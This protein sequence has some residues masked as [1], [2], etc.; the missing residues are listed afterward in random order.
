MSSLFSIRLPFEL[1][2]FQDAPASQDV[3]SQLT[4]KT[5]SHPPIIQESTTTIQ[6]QQRTLNSSNNPQQHRILPGNTTHQQHRIL[7]ANPHHITNNN[8]DPIIQAKRAVL[9][10]RHHDHLALTKSSQDNCTNARKG[11]RDGIGMGVSTGVGMVE[12]GDGHS[13]REEFHNLLISMYKSER[14]S[15]TDNGPIVSKSTTPISP[16]AITTNTTNAITTGFQES[17][18]PATSTGMVPDVEQMKRMMVKQ[19]ARE[20]AES[21]Q[22]ALVRDREVE[23]LKQELEA[24]KKTLE[25]SRE[26]R[27]IEVRILQYEVDWFLYK[28]EGGGKGNDCEG[29]EKRP[30]LSMR[31]K[32]HSVL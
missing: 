29:G 4:A 2:F 21:A 5:T 20:M 27:L 16:T 32:L 7:P 17:P 19:K 1:S 25:I 28:V 14:S 23:N 6:H 18:R 12:D 11:S 13:T 26:D 9:Q 8:E 22:R 10:H 24:I 15:G 31:T 30:A 3:P